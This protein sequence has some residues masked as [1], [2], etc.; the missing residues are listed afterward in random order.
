[1]EWLSNGS[2]TLIIGILVPIFTILAPIWAFLSFI[3]KELKEWRKET[4]EEI[5]KIQTE[6]QEQ[7]KRTDKLYEM[8]VE[9]RKDMDERSQRFDQKFYDLLLKSQNPKTNP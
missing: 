8:F 9:A 3:Y 4:R 2:W 1:M 7:A 5:N 6:I